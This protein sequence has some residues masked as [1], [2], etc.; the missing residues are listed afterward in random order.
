VTTINPG[1]R[2]N[3]ADLEAA[4]LLLERLGISPADLLASPS[5]RPPVPTFA[6]YI[7]IV[8]AAVTAGTRRVYGS[9]WNRVRELWGGRRLDEPTPSE[10]RQLMGYVKAPTSSRAATPGVGAVRPSTWSLPCAVCI[11]MPKTTG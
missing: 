3:T 11:G 9:Y 2:P 8:S 4:R 1:S 7:P 5:Q 6:E 10:I